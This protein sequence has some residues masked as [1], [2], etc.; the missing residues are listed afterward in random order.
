[1]S[2]DKKEQITIDSAIESIKSQLIEYMPA[3]KKI[4]KLEGAFEA[5]IQIKGS[6]EDGKS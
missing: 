4:L 3:H 2:K 1:M 6:E 5:L